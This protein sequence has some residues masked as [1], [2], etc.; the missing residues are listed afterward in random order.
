MAIRV[1]VK[2]R[3]EA[4]AIERALTDPEVKAIAVALGALQELVHQDAR[5][6]AL[7]FLH[8]WNA[9]PQNNG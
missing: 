7:R 3:Q 9:R 1:N 6:R 5:G 2:D 8:E 4:R